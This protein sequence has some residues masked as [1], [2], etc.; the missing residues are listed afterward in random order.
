MSYEIRVRSSV[1]KEVF[2]DTDEVGEYWNCN[3]VGNFLGFLGKIQFWSGTTSGD[4]VGELVTRAI[5][6][7]KDNSFGDEN[8][9]S[10]LHFNDSLK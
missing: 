1:L 10:C 2:L 9:W 7:T 3:K 4:S 5:T 8:L 6:D